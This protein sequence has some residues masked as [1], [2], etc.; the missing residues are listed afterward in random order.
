M[1]FIIDNIHAR[2]MNIIEI[3]TFIDLKCL[4]ILEMCCVVIINFRHDYLLI[5]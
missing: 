5:N 1:I 2:D 3:C 4:L